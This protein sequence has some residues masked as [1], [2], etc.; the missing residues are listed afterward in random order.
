[1]L[2]CVVLG[3]VEFNVFS[4][5]SVCDCFLK[6]FVIIGILTKNKSVKQGNE[7][8]LHKSVTEV[9]DNGAEFCVVK[10]CKVN[11]VIPDHQ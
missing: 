10:C 3:A 11:G 8:Q 2:F 7:K 4:V 1:M 6:E 9:E 5:V